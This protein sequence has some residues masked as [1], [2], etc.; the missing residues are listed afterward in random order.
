MRRRPPGIGDHR[1]LRAQRGRKC[2]LQTR[3]HRPGKGR[4]RGQGRRQYRLHLKPD[5]KIQK[6]R[7]YRERGD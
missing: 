1:R 5:R 4:Y 6:K 3:I 7:Q 2:S